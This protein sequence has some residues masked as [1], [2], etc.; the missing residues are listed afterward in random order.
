MTGVRC[1]RAVK[2]ESRPAS[3]VDGL[4]RGE[5]ALFFELS[6]ETP[7]PLLSDLGQAPADA[8]YSQQRQTEQRNGRT[9]VGQHCRF[10]VAICEALNRMPTRNTP[11][12]S[13]C[14][15]SSPSNSG[16]DVIIGLSSLQSVDDPKRLTRID[17]I[18]EGGNYRYP[19]KGPVW[20]AIVFRT[21]IVRR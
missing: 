13:W 2:L 6:G 4:R 16:N 14:D 8:L 19:G 18:V 15:R 1:G 20:D 17:P 11:T 12:R 7:L 10:A 9:R 5:P 3:A 21:K